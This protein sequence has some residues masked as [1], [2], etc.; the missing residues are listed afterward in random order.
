MKKTDRWALPALVGAILL[1]AVTWLTAAKPAPAPEPEPEPEPKPVVREVKPQPAPPKAPEPVVEEKEPEPEPEPKF[2]NPL[3]GEA[4]ETDMTGLRPYAVMINNISVA[5]PP[6]GVSN[7]DMV[8]E[9]MD[10]GGITRT[11]VL[12]TDV[13]KAYDIGSIRSARAYNIDV[14]LAF[15]AYLVH[16]GGSEE[17]K[18][19]IYYSGVGDID[20]VNG[21][22]TGETF[23]RDWS[24]GDY[25]SEHTL[26]AYGQMLAACPDGMG[27]R[28]EHYEEFD[29]TYG[30]VFDKN[31]SA[32]CTSPAS[33]IHVGYS[34]GKTTDFTYDAS[35]KTY[36]A[37]QYGSEYT[38]NGAAAVPFKNVLVLYADTWLQSDG[39]HL[40]I[41]LSGGTGYFATEG[42]YVAINWY[43]SGDYDN[44]H[45]TLEDGTPLKL[46]VGKTFVAVN[47]DGYYYGGYTEFE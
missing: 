36:T 17:A 24:R 18:N 45:F 46:N 34:G 14:A 20:Q 15:D 10:E 11:E 7:A 38:D 28:R 41:D 37:W 3:T 27:L 5:T 42:K 31:A 23:Y 29:R 35:T 16:C 40:S 19:Y 47:Q 13:A 25:G 8:F 43:R 44:F 9:L 4:A 32:Q 1:C 22:Y 12:F 39:L 21:T 26:F 6:R 33:A 30:L 2:T